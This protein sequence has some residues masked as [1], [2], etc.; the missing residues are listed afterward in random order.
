VA[1]I[2]V[3]LLSQAAGIDL[4][5]AGKDTPCQEERNGGDC[6]PNC[7]DCLCCPHKQAVVLPGA[8]PPSEVIARDLKFVA[9]SLIFSTTDP[10]EI[11][12]VPKRR[13]IL[14]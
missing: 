10:D 9:P 11:L 3:R 2:F 13:P 8:L 7:Q 1:L 4:A 5:F 14:T 12:D 6:A